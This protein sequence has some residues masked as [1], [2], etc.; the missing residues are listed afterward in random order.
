MKCPT[1]EVEMKFLYATPD[2]VVEVWECPKCGKWRCDKR[3]G[4]CDK[5]VKEHKAETVH[6][7]YETVQ[8]AKGEWKK[9]EEE[10]N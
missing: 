9:S 4:N 8:T 5:L 7:D 3:T 6:P 2:K 1:H 10:E